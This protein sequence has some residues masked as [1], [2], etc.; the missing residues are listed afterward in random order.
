VS[1]LYFIKTNLNSNPL[2]RKNYSR[3]KVDM[4]IKGI[5]RNH[6]KN[7]YKHVTIFRWLSIKYS[8][9]ILDR[10]D[11]YLSSMTKEN[12]IPAELNQS[13]MRV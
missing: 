7:N 9:G 2:I 5:E 13:S 3:D 4:R 10:G 11:E 8:E 1:N 12:Q 6:I